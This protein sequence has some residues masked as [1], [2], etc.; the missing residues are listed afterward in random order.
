MSGK[1]RLK[2]TPI[3]TFFSKQPRVHSPKRELPNTLPEPLPPTLQEQD[4]KANVLWCTLYNVPN[5]LRLCCKRS[6]ASPAEPLPCST[7][8]CRP[9]S[10]ESSTANVCAKRALPTELE[11]QFG[12][13]MVRLMELCGGISPRRSFARWNTADI[14]RIA[15]DFYAFDFDGHREPSQQIRQHGEEGQTIRWAGVYRGTQQSVDLA[16]HDP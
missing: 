3:T 1:K 4:D 7:T 10:S 15:S 2:A 13:R 9:L 14:V 11:S 5:D 16:G 8:C 6:C 12:G